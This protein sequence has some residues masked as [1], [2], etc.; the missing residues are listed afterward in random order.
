MNTW[1]VG[2]HPIGHYVFDFLKAAKNKKRE[3]LELGEKVFFMKA[4]IMAGQMNLDAGE[5][6]WKDFQWV[7]KEEAQKVMTPKYFAMTRDMLP[8]R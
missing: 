3:T 8:D 2:N 6:G 4:R 5:L 7:T 1:V